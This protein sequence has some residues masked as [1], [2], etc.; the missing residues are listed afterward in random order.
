[1]KGYKLF[2][3][4]KDGTLSPLFINRKQVLEV[5][6]NYEAEDH[7]TPKFKHRPHWH[8]CSEPVAPHLSM[9]LKTGEKRV[10]AEVEFSDYQEMSRPPSQGGKWYLANQMKI[11]T[12][13][14]DIKTTTGES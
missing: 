14:P 5:G 7:P 12:L 1:M 2:R 4:R 3:L 10:W 8:L 9:E 11:V 13:R 6:V